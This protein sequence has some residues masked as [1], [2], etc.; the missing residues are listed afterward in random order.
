MEPSIK[1]IHD[2]KVEI[3]RLKNLTA[4]Q[5]I[6]LK[7]RFAGPSA[8]MATVMSIFPPSPTVDGIRNAGFFKQD[9][10]G[11]LSRFV[12]PLTLNKTLFRN[13]NFIVKTI[14][15]ILS[16]KASGYISE[17]SVG[18]VWDKVKSVFGKLTKKKEEKIAVVVPVPLAAP[19]AVPGEPLGL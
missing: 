16:Q 2:L 3:G 5:G 15:G 4:E 19:V 11:M 1:N 8:I 9:F 6:A 12:L 7:A 14:V 13:S 17:E 10:L 18:G